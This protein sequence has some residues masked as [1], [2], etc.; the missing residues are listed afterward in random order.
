MGERLIATVAAALRVPPSTL[1]LE[2]G[3][4]DLPAWD[5]LAQL[6]VVSEIEA[7]FGVSIPVEQ[8]AEIRHLRDFLRYLEK[9]P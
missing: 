6:N 3:P 2:S 1:T 9:T 5:S 4:G 8:V 7:E